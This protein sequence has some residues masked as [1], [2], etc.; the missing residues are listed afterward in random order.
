MYED[1]DPNLVKKMAVS[2]GDA[3]K[4]T[5]VPIRK[6]R[7]WE[8]K[9]YIQSVVDGE[10]VNRKYDYYALKT[11][12]LIDELVEEGFT[13]DKAAEKVQNRINK[14]NHMHEAMEKNIESD[15]GK[16]K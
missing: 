7:Y 8:E 10:H 15:D 11:I 1:F 9:N 6:I 14:I 3:S 12:V 16:N 2:I 13:L 4:I 5:G